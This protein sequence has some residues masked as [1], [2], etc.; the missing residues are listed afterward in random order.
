VIKIISGWTN[1]GG[2]T[3]ALITLTNELNKFGYNTT[4]YGPHTWHLDKCKSGLLDENFFKNVS[5]DDILICHFLNLGG[6]PNAKKVLLSC[7]EK[8]LFEVGKI[9]QYW[10]E[11]IFI[12][13]KHRL[14]HKDYFGRYSIIPNLKENLKPSDKPNL[15]MV[16]GIIGT[17][18]ENK[19]THISIKRALEDGCEKIYLFGEAV[20]TSYYNTHIKPLL[21]DKV[22]EFGFMSDKQLMYDMIGR[23]YHSSISEVATLVKDECYLTNTKFFGTESSDVPVSTLTNDEIINKWIKLINNN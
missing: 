5:K 6:R 12:N 20:S 14:Y 17:F 19:Q 21:S 1:K 13:Q 15:D 18:D 22:I 2:S 3:A 10:D 23:V 8:N 16:A 4:I 11:A 9:K 7:H